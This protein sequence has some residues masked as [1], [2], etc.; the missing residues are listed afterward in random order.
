MGESSTMMY[1]VENTKERDAMRLEEI[2]SDVI[3]YYGD[4]VELSR[5]VARDGAEIIAYHMWDD[6][7][8]G[9][10]SEDDIVEAIYYL[11]P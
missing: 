3:A 8:Y 6:G 4:V 1:V 5:L 7:F 10:Y 2:I 11:L 9:V